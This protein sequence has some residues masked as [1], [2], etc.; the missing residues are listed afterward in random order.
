MKPH[1]RRALWPDAQFLQQCML[2]A[3]EASPNLRHYFHPYELLRRE[4]LSWVRWDPESWPAWIAE[5]LTPLGG[6]RLR[7]ETSGA[8]RLGVGVEP[9]ARGQGIGSQ[10]LEL[11]QQYCIRQQRTLELTVDPDN[12]RAIRLYLRLGFAPV[13]EEQ[14]MLLMRHLPPPHSKG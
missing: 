9:H 7:P 2:W 12:E 3:I 10:L 6:L 11:A 13:G 8:M 14:G 5:D 4:E 1:Y